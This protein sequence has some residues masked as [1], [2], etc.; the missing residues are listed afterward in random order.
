MRFLRGTLAWEGQRDLPAVLD[1]KLDDVQATRHPGR[2]GDRQD[3]LEA[4]AKAPSLQMTVG[5]KREIDHSHG[6]K[7]VDPAACVLALDKKGAPVLAIGK[8]DAASRVPDH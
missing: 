7:V 3:F 2:F 8:R 1:R 4:T 6:G 5:L